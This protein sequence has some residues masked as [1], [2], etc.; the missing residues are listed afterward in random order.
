MLLRCNTVESPWDPPETTLSERVSRVDVGPC[1]VDRAWQ[2]AETG[3]RS[4]VWGVGSAPA[5]Q[6][7]AAAR[8]GWTERK[9]IARRFQMLIMPMATD[10]LTSS[11]SEK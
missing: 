10:R 5:G 3:K 4:V 11:F 2:G 1:H 6:A 7:A 8:I 9:P